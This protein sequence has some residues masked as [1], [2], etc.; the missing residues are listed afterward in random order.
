MIGDVRGAEDALFRAPFLRYERGGRRRG[1][2]LPREAARG[3]T[4]TG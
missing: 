1:I 3:G 2:G 4:F